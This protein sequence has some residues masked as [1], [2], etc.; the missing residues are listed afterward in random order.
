ALGL[1]EAFL[2]RRYGEAERV[3]YLL[4]G[5]GSGALR[6]AVRTQ[7]RRDSQYVRRARPG[8]LEEGGDRLTVV[9]LR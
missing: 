9:Y 4:H 8:T 5:V 6:D 7:L 3:A 1:V 2:D